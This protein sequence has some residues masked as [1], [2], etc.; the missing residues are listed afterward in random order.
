MDPSCYSGWY[1]AY[2]VASRKGELMGAFSIWHWLV[3]LA[4]LGTII[5]AAKALGRVGLHPAWAILSI[6]PV[7]GWFAMWAFA[8]ARWPNVDGR[9]DATQN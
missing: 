6:I 9:G 2:A 5:P 8:Y 3:V 7:L 4:A 1:A